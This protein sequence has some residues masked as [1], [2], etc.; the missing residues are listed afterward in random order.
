MGGPSAVL[1]WMPPAW[2]LWLRREN[3]SWIAKDPVF[4][5]SLQ[6]KLMKTKSRRIEDVDKNMR[7]KRVAAPDALI[8][9]PAS[10][11]RLNI[12]GLAWFKENQGR[13]CRL[14]LRAEGKVSD[15]TWSLAQCPASGHLAFRSDTTAMAVR[16]TNADTGH[17]PH[18]AALGS[19]GVALQCGAPGQ[20]RPWASATP[21]LASPSF[22]RELF[23]DV[24]RKMR[25]FRLYLPLYQSLQK[26]EVGVDRGVHFLSPSPTTL[27]QPVVFYGTSIT[28]GGCASTPANDFVS[29][30]GRKLNLEM[31]NLGFSGNGDY[32]PAL[33]RYISEI[34][35]ALYV[36]DYA[37]I[38]A[39]PLSQRLPVFVEILRQSHPATPIL[40]VTPTC[41]SGYDWFSGTR[42]HLD[43]I[44]DV[45]LA[46]YVRRRPKDRHIHFVDGYG[47]I[48]FGSDSAQV[49]GC[50]PSDHGFRLI[51]DRLAPQIA[52]IILRDS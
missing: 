51:A 14:P 8:W 20:M 39:G 36:L 4:D 34:N 12:R 29:I 7:A 52:Q 32:A 19:N 11:R 49:D 25:E 23:K 5:T 2:S 33:A 18:M 41:Y 26:L 15:P 42:A 46:Y 43:D 27:Q 45:M 47:L 24:P 10:D 40:L 37:N 13:F 3:S 22:E 17:M 6:K 38:T 31:V 1:L 21:D 50:H 28:Q 16:V 48:P 44:R 30:I 9:I 35:A